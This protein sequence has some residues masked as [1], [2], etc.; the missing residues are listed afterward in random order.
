M[1][2]KILIVLIALISS[3]FVEAEDLFI[4][5]DIRIEGLQKISEGAL[6]NY[7]PVNIGDELDDIRIKE[8]L[9]SVYSSGFFKNIEFR[10][11][12][13]G[14][15]IISV[16]ERPS[17]ASITFEGNKDI[18]TEDLQESLN[19]IGF[20]IGRNYDPSIL[21][22]IE[23]SLIDQ[24]FSFGKYS[25]KVK[26]TVEDLPGNSV[27]VRVDVNEGDRAQ[28]RQINIVGNSIFSDE[29][30]LERLTLQMPNWLSFINQDD[31]YSR[32]DLQG[33]LENIES[34]YQDQGYANF[35]IDSAQVAISQDKTGIFV[36]INISEGDVYT[37]SDVKLTGEFVIPRER[38]ENLVFAQPGQ[39][40][41]Q[42]L[43]TSISE[44]IE[45]ELGEEGYSFAEVEAIPELDRDNREVKVVFYI[46]PKSR[47]YVRRVN[48]TDTT[49]IN[50]NTLRRELR[51]LEGGY[52]SKS[53]LERS[54][55]RLQRLPFIEEVEFDTIPV[56]GTND[57]IDAEF[58]IKEGLPG[59][60]GAGVG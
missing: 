23:R 52:Y 38:I 60:F 35:S 55:I 9:R 24:Y 51:Q 10:K 15:L 14:T 50:D 7:L 22:E 26:T 5:K 27:S 39:I 2:T 37:L 53:R 58:K 25:A 48:F 31:R 59:Q 32:E 57:L 17:I 43:L 56:A 8:S 46:Q 29:D 21:D 40:F 54:K 36:T 41:S 4:V 44:L 30:L 49:S 11:D 45:Y 16:L 18:K 33:D 3:T 13:S 1:K 34:F 47:V 6:L 28:I 19:N 42:G 12:D 20:K